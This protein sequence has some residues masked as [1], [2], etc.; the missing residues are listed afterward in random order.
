MTA[1]NLI[2][3]TDSMRSSVSSLKRKL[4]NLKIQIEIFDAEIEKI[5]GKFT[6]VLTQAEIYKAKLEREMGREVRRLT[7]ELDS[8]KRNVRFEYQTP[9]ANKTELSIASTVA[10]LESILSMASDG[11]DDFRLIS[12]AFL[13]PAVIERVMAGIDQTYFLDSVPDSASIIVDRGREYLKW[14]RQEYSTHLTNPSTWE[15][16]IEPICDWWRNDALPLL[17][18]CRDE[19]WDIDVPLTHT[20]MMIWKDTPSERPFILPSIFDAYEIYNKNKDTVY[21]TTGL[22]EFEYKHLTP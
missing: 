19:K 15:E 7:K 13:F 12:R 16:A 6:K 5:E 22:F 17:Y 8:L 14:L 11:A 10:I 1:D 4:S 20:E 21:E 2:H 3:A 18:G 9:T